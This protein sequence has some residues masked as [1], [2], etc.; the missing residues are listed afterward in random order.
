MCI[1]FVHAGQLALRQALTH[2]ISADLIKHTVIN[3]VD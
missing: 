1:T 3:S 2:G